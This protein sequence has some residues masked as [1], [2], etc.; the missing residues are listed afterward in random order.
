MNDGLCLPGT[1]ESIYMR[2]LDELER[3]V[4]GRKDDCLVERRARNI[5]Q[6]C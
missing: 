1:M 6:K 5:V 3:E 4:A 2:P